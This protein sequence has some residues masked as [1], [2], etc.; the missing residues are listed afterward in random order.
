MKKLVLFDI[1]GTLIKGAYKHSRTRYP[2]AYKKLFNKT[3][4][5]NTSYF[6]GATDAIIVNTILK[7]EKL[8]PTDKKQFTQKMYEIAYEYLAENIKSD[9]KKRVI[10]DAVKLVK[11]LYKT[12]EVYLALLTGNEENV[13]R[14]K[15]GITGLSY[16]FRFGLFGNQAEN[17]N[18][19]ATLVFKKAKQFLKIDFPPK[20]IYIIG[21]TPNDVNCGKYIKANTIAVSTGAISNDD[22]KKTNPDILVNS[23]SDDKVINFILK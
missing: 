16:Y 20:D 4:N 17:R 6:E 1:D 13:A 11:K 10:K 12:P 8:S 15:I 18:K 21:D 3:F 23:L 2:T 14:L 7:P 19:L 9:Y 5:T 22:L